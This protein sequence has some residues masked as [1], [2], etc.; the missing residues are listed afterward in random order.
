MWRADEEGPA[1][2]RL[3]IHSPQP[4]AQAAKRKDLHMFVWK[5]SASPVSERAGCGAVHVF[6]AGAD[7]GDALAKGTQ[8]YDEYGS[9]DFSRTKN[10]NGADKGGLTLSKLGSNS[11]AQLYPKVGD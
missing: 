6:G 8:A 11:T 3:E 4:H 10:G 2:V 7:H 5:S 1:H 9:D